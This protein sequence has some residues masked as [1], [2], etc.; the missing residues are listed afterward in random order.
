MTRGRS[1]ADDRRGRRPGG[2]G[3]IIRV[4]ALRYD[5]G[6]RHGNLRAAINTQDERMMM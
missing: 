6:N 2:G 1:G 5:F 4:I 3:A